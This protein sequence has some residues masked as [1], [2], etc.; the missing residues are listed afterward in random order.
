M[1][2]ESI[3]DQNCPSSR[4]LMHNA[5]LKKMLEASVLYINPFVIDIAEIVLCVYVKRV[6]KNS[7]KER[8]LKIKS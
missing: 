6:W 4:S 1:Y 2:Q 8:A 7:V 5:G 3:T